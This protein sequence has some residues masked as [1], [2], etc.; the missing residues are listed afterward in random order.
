MFQGG[1]AGSAVELWVGSEK[2]LTLYP[3]DHNELQEFPVSLNVDTTQ[4]LIL[5]FVQS[6]DFYGRITVYMLNIYGSSRE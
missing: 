5:K 1:F 2:R 4:E 3:C 6:T